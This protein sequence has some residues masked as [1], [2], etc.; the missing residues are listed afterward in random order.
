MRYPLPVIKSVWRRIR[1]PKRG[2]V[3]VVQGQPFIITRA[4]LNN[5]KPFP[6]LS[7]TAEQIK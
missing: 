1:K 6:E 4:V 5:R 7:I 3:I 2:S